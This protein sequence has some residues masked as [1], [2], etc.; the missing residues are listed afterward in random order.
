M[1]ILQA[2]TNLDS[3]IQGALIVVLSFEVLSNIILKLCSEVTKSAFKV[4]KAL[5]CILLFTE[6]DG[7]AKLRIIVLL[8][9]GLVVLTYKDKI[10]D[11]VGLRAPLI[12]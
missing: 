1:A 5:F 10:Q 4:A 2:K 6:K 9:L 12:C 3:F 8:L 7:M 11:L